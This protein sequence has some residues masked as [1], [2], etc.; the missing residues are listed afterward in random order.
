MYT[1]FQIFVS[2]YGPAKTLS[3]PAATEVQ[4]VIASPILPAP[5]PFTN[6]VVEP[7][8]MGIACGGQGT[9]PG[10]KCTVLTSP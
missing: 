3:L 9:P 10:N 4:D 6:T 7:V 5:S 8:V 2:F 1:C